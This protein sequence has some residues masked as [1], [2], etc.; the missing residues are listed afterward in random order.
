MT[1]KVKKA[2]KTKAK[3]AAP[4]ALVEAE[5]VLTDEEKLAASDSICPGC[6][7]RVI[8]N[9]CRLCGAR[10][11]INSVSGNVIWMRN[12][13]IVPG[14]AFQDDKNAYVQMA[15]RSGIPMSEWPEKF[16]S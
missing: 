8:E 1:E 15:Q 6:L 4:V 5:K 13:R 16:R 12:G 11:T 9:K 10:K 14:G 3:P 2:K 7:V